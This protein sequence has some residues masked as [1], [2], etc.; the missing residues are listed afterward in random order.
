MESRTE[1]CIALYPAANVTGSWI[2]WNMITDSY[3]RRTNWIKMQM[4]STVIDKMNQLAL[5]EDTVQKA[6]EIAKGKKEPIPDTKVSVETVTPR[7]IPTVPT[8]TIQ[9]VE[10]EQQ[11]AL[12]VVSQAD[13]GEYS[14]STHP[15]PSKPEIRRSERQK[16]KVRKHDNEF[17]YSLN[18]MSVKKGLAKHGI[19]AKQAIG[20]EFE[21]LFKRKRVLQPIRRSSLTESQRRKIIRSSMFLK[22]KYDGLGRFEKLKGRLVADGRM[23]DR[24]L[25]SDKVS[26]TA[27][28]ESIFIELTLAV[29]KNKCKAKVDIGGAYLNAFIEDGDQIYMEL[30]RE[31]TLI[32]VELFPELS[33]YVDKSGR[34]LVKI[35]KALYGLVQSAALWYKVLTGFLQSLGFIPNS[36]DNCVMNMRS[37]GRDITVVLY[38]DDLLIL[39][40]SQSDIDWLID[41]LKKE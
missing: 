39:S 36:L 37:N 17:E 20:A 26:P 34:L 32:L 25:Y 8:M 33:R 2:M 27:K 29:M 6:D 1:P 40:T 35:L 15:E 21:Q 5:G 13:V 22:E 12:E 31:L 38:V 10:A 3:V 11:E 16:N 4:T 18:Q 7:E 30:S 14:E 41:E 19:Q 24:S 9:E 23:Q 28:L